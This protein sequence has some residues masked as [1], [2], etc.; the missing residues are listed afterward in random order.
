MMKDILFQDIV[1]KGEREKRGREGGDKNEGEGRGRGG[2][3]SADPTPYT[4]H[5]VLGINW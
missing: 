1:V 4:I 2:V 5:G 3:L